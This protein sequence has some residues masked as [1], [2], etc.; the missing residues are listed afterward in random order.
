MPLSDKSDRTPAPA[1]VKIF[2]RALVLEVRMMYD[3]D[4][5]MFLFMCDICDRTRA[6]ALILCYTASLAV[7]GYL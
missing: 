5:V 2:A 1:V 7:T 6:Q 4:D 3:H